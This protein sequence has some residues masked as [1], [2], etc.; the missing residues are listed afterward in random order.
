MQILITN[1]HSTYNAGDY[2]ILR[3]T[4]RQ[5]YETFPNASVTILLNNPQTYCS[6]GRETVVGS[7]WSW[8]ISLDSQGMLRIHVWKL[9]YFCFVLTMASLLYRAT[10]VRVYPVR[11]PA[12]RQ[13]LN[14][15][16]NAHLVL[17][18]GGGYLYGT[19]YSN[20]WFLMLWFM[21][22]LAAMLKKPFVLLPQSI[23]PIETPFQHRLL[24]WLLPGARL[25]MVRESRTQHLLHQLG[26]HHNVVLSP[27][28][29]FGIEVNTLPMLD[30]PW[31][32][33]QDVSLR[34]G[35][36]LLD[37]HGHGNASFDQDSYEQAMLALINHMTRNKIQVILFIQ[38]SGPTRIEDDR[39]VTQA[40]MNQVD[41]PELVF[42]L[43][44]NDIEEYLAAYRHID[45]FIGTRLHSAIFAL[46]WY[47][48]VL[49]IGY[50]QKSAGIMEL[51]NSYDYHI[52]IEN[53]TA[54][55]LIERFELLYQARATLAEQLTQTIPGIH[56]EAQMTI[57]RVQKNWEVT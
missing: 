53:V 54:Q 22:A 14:A 47:I 56:E 29:A 35:M 30:P 1:V 43:D 49:V 33:A 8:V 55:Q 37:W 57:Q 11:S 5:V 27:D 34:V 51:T 20:A 6:P 42:L 44:K 2:A 16:F 28:I 32:A 9:F 24:R 45:L 10:G 52:P 41:H 46:V 18:I 23:G 4:L 48:P 7:L 26:I 3:E 21:I 39:R 50:L 19:K 36:T 40:V 38:V 31:P 13:L 17:A 25:I 15:Y 12:K